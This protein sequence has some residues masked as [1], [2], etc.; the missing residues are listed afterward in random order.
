MAIGKGLKFGMEELVLESFLVD[1]PM[2]ITQ[3][4]FE[5]YFGIANSDIM[6]GQTAM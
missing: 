2:N 6:T 1:I 5:T 3:T 4:G